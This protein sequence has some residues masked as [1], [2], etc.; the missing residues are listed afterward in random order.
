MKFEYPELKV[1]MF[2]VEDVLTTSPCGED[3]IDD[4]CWD[5]YAC[6]NQL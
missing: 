6:P 4:I 1:Q 3:C 5:D 2:E